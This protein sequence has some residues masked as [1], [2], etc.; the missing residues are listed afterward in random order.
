ML[1]STLL[2]LPPLVAGCCT[3]PQVVAGLKQHAS[4]E[5]LTGRLVALVLNLKPAKLA[6]E[7]SEA[8]VL[9]ADHTPVGGTRAGLLVHGQGL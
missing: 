9:A 1:P 8:M 5:E 4:R 3:L 7:L 2:P 6:G